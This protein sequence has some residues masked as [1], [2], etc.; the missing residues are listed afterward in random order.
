MNVSVILKE[1]IFS[2]N[3]FYN[4]MG[5]LQGYSLR[6]LNFI[7]ESLQN[8]LIAVPA[9]I[10]SNIGFSNIALRTSNY[11]TQLLFEK[12][13]FLSKLPTKVLDEIDIKK[14]RNVIGAA[15]CLGSY[16]LSVSLLNLALYK[17]V[18]MKLSPVMYTAV[19]V[20]TCAAYFFMRSEDVVLD[21]L[22]GQA[23]HKIENIFKNSFIY[24]MCASNV[25]DER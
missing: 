17:S 19:S 13:F 11:V 10:V 7:H 18:S 5:R 22:L 9:V 14:V 12:G 24:K 21:A 25:P 6:L 8:K 3:I 16:T 4:Q 20:T 2:E 1:N 23:K 15:I